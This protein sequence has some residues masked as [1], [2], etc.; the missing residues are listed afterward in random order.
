MPV[1]GGMEATA[2]IR[3]REGGGVKRTPI[4]A[5]TANAMENDRLQCLAAGMDGYIS[6]PFKNDALLEVLRKYSHEP[7]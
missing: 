6:K 7:A 4:V 3:A 5:M 1:M 2:E